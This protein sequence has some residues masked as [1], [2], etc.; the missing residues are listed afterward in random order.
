MCFLPSPS[1]PITISGGRLLKLGAFIERNPILIGLGED[2]SYGKHHCGTFSRRI[3]PNGF[4]RVFYS[5]GHEKRWGHRNRERSRSVVIYD[6]FAWIPPAHPRRE[7]HKFARERKIKKQG[8]STASEKIRVL[9]RTVCLE[10][11]EQFAYIVCLREIHLTRSVGRYEEKAPCKQ[12]MC[13][14]YVRSWGRQ[15][16]VLDPRDSLFMFFVRPTEEMWQGRATKW[17]KMYKTKESM[18]KRTRIHNLFHATRIALL[19]TA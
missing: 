18:S 17:M 3:A 19:T 15:D 5:Y 16:F 2:R 1:R 4:R 6:S 14:C 7:E 9:K 10:D 11:K 13:V 8:E 12:A